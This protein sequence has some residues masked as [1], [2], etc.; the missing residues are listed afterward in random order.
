MIYTSTSCLKN[1]QNIIKVL[2]EYEKGGIQN[3]ELGS[4]HSY[5]QTKN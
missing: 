3:V 5:F 4:V 2:D 1:P